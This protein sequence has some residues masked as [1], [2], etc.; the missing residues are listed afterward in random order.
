M[1]R[2]MMRQR[3]WN[4]KQCRY[5]SRLLPLLA[6]VLVYASAC[7]T[8]PVPAAAPQAL[9]ISAEAAARADELLELGRTIEPDL[10]DWLVA[11]ADRLDF[12]LYGLRHRVKSRA[13]LERKIQTNMLNNGIPA[14]E[15]IIDD[16]LR[17][18]MLVTDDPPGRYNDAV[19]D[20]LERIENRG[21]VVH[22]V[23][24]YWPAGD[25]YSGI[26]C[27]LATPEGLLWELQ[28]HTV[29]SLAAKQ[30]AH[31]LYEE[32]RLPTTPVREKRRLFD[33]MVERWKWVRIPDGILEPYSVHP[34]EEIILRDRP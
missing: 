7:T 14:Q 8:V 23:E 1:E 24:N 17:Y 21:Y 13:S 12:Q 20:I 26:N 15:V 19:S 33:E 5:V 10:T 11:G 27:V 25:A 18:T 9:E 4:S 2:P 30:E 32:F 22:E 29:G 31:D 28:L 3:R 34:A 16:V 6:V